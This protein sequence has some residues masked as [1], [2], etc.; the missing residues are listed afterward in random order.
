M[1]SLILIFFP[2]KSQPHIF[3]FNFVDGNFIFKL[4][5]VCNIQGKL[6][7]VTVRE[8]KLPFGESK[9]VRPRTTT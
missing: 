4:R 3:I 9:N 1:I 7:K 6:K 5:A 8:L 2:S